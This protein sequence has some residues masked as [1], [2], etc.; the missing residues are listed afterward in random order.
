MK[1]KFAYFIFMLL[2]ITSQVFATTYYVDATNGNDSNSGISPSAAWKTIE[3]VNDAMKYGVISTGDDILF[4]R[5]ETFTDA[6]LWIR[7]GGN[8]DNYM[9]I[10]DYGSG[11][12]PT[13]DNDANIHLVEGTNYIKIKNI[14]IQNTAGNSAGFDLTRP[15]KESILSINIQ[16]LNC[17]AYNT[18]GA[19]IF[20]K[21][22]DTFKI[23]GCI[24]DGCGNGGIVVYGSPIIK[25]TNGIIS[26]NITKNITNEDGITIHKDMDGYDPGSNITLI[27][28]ESY[29]NQENGIDICGG[30]YVTIE[31]NLLHDNSEANL[32]LGGDCSNIDIKRNYI[33]GGSHHAIQIVSGSSITFK[34]NIVYDPYY[35]CLE[36]APMIDHTIQTVIAYNNTFVSTKRS[37][38]PTIRVWENTS[39]FDA[40]NNIIMSTVDNEQRLIFFAGS[41]TPVNT[42][43]NF[44]HN[45]WWRADANPSIPSELLD[46][47]SLISDPKL[48]NPGA[49]DFYLQSNSPCIDT[50]IDVG[51]TQD[52][53]GNSV[54]Q[55]SAPD[56]G[57]L[58][59]HG[60]TSFQSFSYDSTITLELCLFVLI[61]TLGTTTYYKKRKYVH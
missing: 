8:P 9:V 5:G 47:S 4:K 51:I 27:N 38:R 60:S 14:K 36:L 28:N 15:G 10:G 34:S 19:G 57:A 2:T 32:V 12:L 1:K 7:V 22:I 6:D 26:N 25:A 44:D 59:Y 58:E 23:D 20:V 42:N 18:G 30:H 24:V 45:I 46:Q 21:G 50:G 43:S 54:P 29:N 37:E 35:C 31:G 33:Y 17:V 56:I 16:V 55:G 39:S 53:E 61:I 3:H 49:G 11:D 13:L 41:A 52:F 48:V 40:K